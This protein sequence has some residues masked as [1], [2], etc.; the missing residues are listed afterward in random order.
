[1]VNMLISLPFHP[2]QTPRSWLGE[3][4]GGQAPHRPHVLR[5]PDGQWPDLNMHKV[6]REKPSR[7]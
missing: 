5:V 4:T 6:E 1:M 3:Q 2:G 7:R